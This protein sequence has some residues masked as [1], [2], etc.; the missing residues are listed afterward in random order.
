M[1][2]TVLLLV[3]LPLLLATTCT[4]APR[5]I[6]VG[7]ILPLTGTTAGYGESC[8]QGI[9]MAV[10]DI[11]VK[12]IKG[13]RIALRIEDNQGEDDLAAQAATRLIKQSKVVAILGPTESS[14]ALEAARVAQKLG[15]PLLTPSA[16]NPG[17][18]EVGNYISRICYVDPFQG[19]VM[20][21]FAFRSLGLR[22]AAVVIDSSMD[23]SRGL[24]EFFTRKF[25]KSGGTIVSREYYNEGATTFTDLIAALLKAKPEIVF[26]PGY[27]SEVGLFLQAAQDAGLKSVFLGGDGWDSPQLFEL[28][29]KALSVPNRCYICSHFSPEDPDTM[30]QTFDRRYRAKYDDTPDA[31]GALGYDATMVLADAFRRALGINRE[32]VRDA[33][34]STYH[35]PGVTGLI[36][37]DEKRN[38]VKSAVVL[39]SQGGRFVFLEKINP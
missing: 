24:A 37:L 27:Y 19:E 1:K 17:V 21:N 2:K 34:N 28:A 39:K 12:G 14:S 26:I 8:L 35:F 9:K 32:A 36:S 25:E 23:Y 20:A 30:V 38:A 29:G 7:V 13:Q 5:E 31:S 22:K 18:T 11:N 6:P 10:E 3:I 4:R 33:I 15:V 16:T